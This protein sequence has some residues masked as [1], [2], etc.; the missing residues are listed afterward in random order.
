MTAEAVV[1]AAEA[2]ALRASR[3]MRWRVQ[4]FAAWAAE[5]AGLRAGCASMHVHRILTIAIVPSPVWVRRECPD[6]AGA[7]R[8][9]AHCSGV[10]VFLF[11]CSSRLEGVSQRCIYIHHHAMVITA[12][13]DWLAMLPVD[14]NPL[15]P[16]ATQRSLLHW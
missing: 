2:A 14:T 12:C 3:D 16:S 6:P 4:G 11:F 7:Q 13:I 10:V 1:T 8:A 5:A 15:K 9:C